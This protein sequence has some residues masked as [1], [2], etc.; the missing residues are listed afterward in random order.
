VKR[1]PFRHLRAFVPLFAITFFVFCA[2]NTALLEPGLLQQAYILTLMLCVVG[3]LAFLF[4]RISLALFLGGGLF[5]GLK[6]ISV[7]KL[8]YL[9]SPLMPADFIYFARD[10]LLETLEHYPNLLGLSVTLCIGAPLICWLVWWLDYRPL[11]GLRHQSSIIVRAAGI[12]AFIGAFWICLLPGGPFKPIYAKGLWKTLSDDAHLTN[13]FELIHDSRAQLPAR[14]EA[15]SA[16]QLWAPTVKESAREGH[17]L[18][19]T[20]PDIILVLE[21]STF[22]PSNF[23]GCTIPQ[24]HVGMFQPDQYTRA[25]G[26]LRTHT[27][28]GGTWVSEFA[29]LSGMPQNI[30]GPAGMYAPYVLAPRLRDSLPMQLRRD[31]YLTIAV[32]PVGGSFINARNAY[33]AYGFDKFYDVNDIGLRMWHT[34][35]SQLFA[36]ARK[37]YDENRKSGKPIFI[38]VLTM[39][40]HGPHDTLPLSRLPTPFDKGLLP[41]L[42]ASQ[43]LNLSTYLSRLQ[44]SNEGMTQLESYFLHRPEPTVIVHFGDHQPSFG[45]LIRDMPRTLPAELAPYKDNLTYFMLKTNF[46]TSRLPAPPMLDIAYLPSMVLQAARLRQDPYFSALRGLETRCNGRYVDCPDKSLLTSFYGWIFD[47]LHVYE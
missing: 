41:D 42:S 47:H 43:Q 36:A 15:P 6:F 46:A 27:F 20:N 9:E 21:E 30:F 23:T 25:H 33:R 5:L 45:G 38:M 13:F 17:E 35:D 26:P 37:V 32:Y 10:S 39:G 4:G 19:K 12:F 18:A 7:V 44:D 1:F 22:D 14:S 24:C 29:V 16:E 11:A 40:Q 3:A 34:S 28:G 2:Y 31:G 8:R